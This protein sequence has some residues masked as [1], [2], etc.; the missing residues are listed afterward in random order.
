VSSQA[1]FAEFASASAKFVM[2]NAR[3]TRWDI[4]KNVPRFA[5]AVQTNA[6]VWQRPHSPTDEATA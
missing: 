2:T 5:T 3:N 1:P 6:A 4:A